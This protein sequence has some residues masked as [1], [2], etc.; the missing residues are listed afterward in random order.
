MS[1]IAFNP[2][3][4]S[5]WTGSI[6]RTGQAAASTSRASASS[7]SE[8]KNSTEGDRIEFSDHA[9]LVSKALSD[10]ATGYDPVPA[11]RE[12]IASGAYDLEGRLNEAIEGLIA[13]LD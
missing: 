2:G 1:D 10:E 11:L 13:D 4:G 5:G 7:T 6:D 3:V 12:A 8:N 9:A